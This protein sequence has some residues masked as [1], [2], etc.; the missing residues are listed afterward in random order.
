M[1]T[2]FEKLGVFY[3]GKRFDTEARARRD[4]VVLYD[5]K[6]L[7][8]HAVCVGMTGSGKTGLCVGLLEE[9]AIDGVPAIVI[10]PKGD[11]G[12]LLLQ[13]PNL[14]AAEFAPWIN[15]DDA[16]RKGVEPEHY[17]QQQ[18]QVWAKGL[19]DWGQSG[20]R[21]RRMQQAADFAI[22]TPG[23]N[24]GTPVSIL[25]SFA[26]PPTAVRDDIELFRDRVSGTASSVL[27]LL[28]IDADPM[29]S[30]E[31]ILIASILSQAWSAG[32]DLDL[33]GLIHD[34]Q[35]PPFTR[36]G[37]M[38]L[39]SVYPGKD[40]FALAMSF[41]NLAAS[42]GFSAWLAGEPL[43]IQSIL[44]TPAGKPRI[45]V[46]SIAHLS[47]AERMFFVSLLLN[48]V[49]AW[50]RTQS[51][52]T[53]LRALLY[54]D[55]IAGYVPPTA[56]P[57]SKRPLLT[58]MK[59]ARAFGVGVVLA[60]QNPIDLDYKGLS[61][62]GTW[63]IGR[64]QAERDKLRLLD[65][66]EGAMA[67]APGGFDRAE[68]DRLL[69]SLGPRVFLMHNVHDDSP[70]V[71]ETR[72]CMSYLRG[73]LTR[74]ELKALTES[75]KGSAIGAAT[76]ETMRAAP[77]PMTRAPA[78][79]PGA[80]PVLP[81]DVPQ[82]FLPVRTQT[83]INYRPMV[84]GS[85]R[86][87]YADSKSGIDTELSMTLLCPV[88][89]GPVAV[90][91][92]QAQEIEIGEKD[93]ESAPLAGAGFAG[94][95]ADATKAKNFESWKKDLA[96]NVFRSRPLKI[97]RCQGLKVF[98]QPRESERDFAARVAQAAREA[99]D[100]ACDKLRQK[101]TPRLAS[102]QERIR[103]S[104]QQA[105]VQKE[106]AAA[107]KTSTLLSV[108]SALLGA[109]LGKKVVSS[110]NLGRAATAARGVSRHMKES[111]DVTRAQ[112]NIEVLESQMS[113]LE[114]EFNAEVERVAADFDEAAKATD[115]VT[116]KPKKSGIN[117]RA[118]VL[119]WAPFA[120][121]EQAW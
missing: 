48:Q 102:I 13:F 27:G 69:S 116:V 58:L 29:S 77:S 97:R 39:E 117:V 72:W 3:L 15:P 49:L 52:T 81:P 99:R 121:G 32:Q 96:D 20:D 22:Y 19:A 64:L 28:G 17:A 111:S 44:Y 2:D 60:T 8:T 63:F 35:Q 113:T 33:A 7:V 53:S 11:L 16:R 94:V 67:N 6:D 118:V 42:P 30:R 110:G 62:A 103:R 85:V 95:A 91:W 76:S 56:N 21:I 36:L 46:F 57:P 115:I 93:L 38:E 66:L 12:N 51:G 120:E 112:E 101:Y 65:G 100:A 108:G 83:P 4:D 1:P 54:M 45:A 107:A 5:S 34:I 75:R 78:A 40:R 74:P 61:N 59:Q 68:M 43:D 84:L 47:D 90:D 71:F 105:E 89:T 109:F 24:A 87:A 88:D 92:E 106:Q 25:R 104:Q 82:Y 14:S 114:A 55:E 9:A 10:D 119:A 41:N 26:A 70:T 31:H 73:P 18:A 86:V 37:V 98:G 23:S 80:R 50:T 79:S